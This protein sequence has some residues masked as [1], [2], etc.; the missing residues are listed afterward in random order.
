MAVA[1]RTNIQIE[2]I[3]IGEKETTSLLYAYDMTATLANISSVEKVMQNLN[4]F[5][6][7]SDLKMNLSKAKALLNGKNR[8]SLETPLWVFISPVIKN[9]LYNKTSMID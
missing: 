9:K 7:K 5:E 8:N 6:K 1:I 2:G 3:K 4:D